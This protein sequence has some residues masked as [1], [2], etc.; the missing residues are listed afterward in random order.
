ME[1]GRKGL[2][3]TGSYRVFRGGSWGDFARYCRS[4]NR[5]RCGPGYRGYGLGFRVALAPAVQGR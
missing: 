5:L 1:L 3:A 2:P 4:A